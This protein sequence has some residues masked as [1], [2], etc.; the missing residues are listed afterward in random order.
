MNRQDANIKILEI[1]KTYLEKYP[2]IRFNQLLH[3]LNIIEPNRDSFYD[4]SDIVFKKVNNSINMEIY[5]K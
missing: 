4:E 3:N 2:D 1:L 5:E